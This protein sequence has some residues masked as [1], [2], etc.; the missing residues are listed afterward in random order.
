MRK[1]YGE[2]AEQGVRLFTT[3]IQESER[4]IVVLGVAQIDSDLERLL[5]HVLHPSPKKSSDDLF[6]PGGPLGSF[7]AR[8]AFAHRMGIFDSEFVKVL[9]ILR[10]IRNDFAHNAAEPNLNLEQHRSRI[11]DVA[12]WAHQDAAYRRGIEAGTFP[13]MPLLRKKFIASVI[14]IM[15]I[16]RT[17]MLEMQRVDVGYQ[18]RPEQDFPA[19]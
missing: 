7:G 9:N 19:R 2:I 14:T 16:L 5:K 8:I 10:K 15:L 4:A 17:G 1:E 18:L 6:D 12:K 11:E 13:D 3:L